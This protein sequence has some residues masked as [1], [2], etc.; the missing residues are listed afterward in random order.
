MPE[1]VLSRIHKLFNNKKARK[2]LL[3]LRVPLG[4]ILF[5]LLSRFIDLRFFFIGLAVSVLG[6]LFQVWCMSTIKTKKKLTI[7]GPYMFMRNPMYIGRFFLIFGIIMMTG[8]P[9]LMASLT[10][11]YYFYMV[12]RVKREEEILSD[13]FGKAYEDYC[14]KVNR[15]IPSFRRFDRALLWSFN[16]ESFIQNNV[17]W[18]ILG[19]AICYVILYSFKLFWITY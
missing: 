1:N 7:V 19:V 12:N 15:Y 17:H 11:L 9:W 13:L 18:N 6:E 3:K 2:T 8:N 14:R 4:L 16:K 10:I 5:V